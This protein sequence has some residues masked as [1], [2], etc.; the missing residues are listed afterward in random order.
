MTL[1]LIRA[2]AVCSGSIFTQGPLQSFLFTYT[3]SLCLQK[4]V[5]GVEPSAGFTPS[6]LPRFLAQDRHSFSAF[7]GIS[8]EETLR[9]TL[10]YFR[11]PHLSFERDC[12]SRSIATRQTSPSG[13]RKAIR[14]PM[15]AICLRLPPTRMIPSLRRI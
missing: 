4:R 8:I 11:R 9:S 7:E 2:S 15:S 12:C 10:N 3:L 14:S 13:I 5:L 6:G 1:F